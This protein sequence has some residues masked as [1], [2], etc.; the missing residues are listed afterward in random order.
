MQIWNMKLYLDARFTISGIK[1]E[2][3]SA[4]YFYDR[5]K[6]YYRHLLLFF[7]GKL[8]NEPLA[9]HDPFVANSPEEIQKAIQ[10]Y[11]KAEFGGWPHKT[12]EPTH[13]RKMGRFAK[14]ANG[15]EK[16]KS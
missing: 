14:F 13:E 4:L 6:S 16:L 10:V 3:T 8:I 1:K 5:F 15:E 7:Q 2:V 9:Q 12:N 11:G